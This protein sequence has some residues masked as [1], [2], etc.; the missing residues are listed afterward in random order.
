M[1]FL[2]K[3]KYIVSEIVGFCIVA[4]V[5]GGLIYW[6]IQKIERTADE[7]DKIRQVVSDMAERHNAST[8]WSE[9]FVDYNIKINGG[10]RPIYTT[11]VKTALIMNDSKP[12]IFCGLIVDVKNIDAEYYLLFSTFRDVDITFKLRCDNEQAER[13]MSTPEGFYVIVAVISNIESSDFEIDTSHN[14]APDVI[15]INSF[16]ANGVCLDFIFLGRD[17]NP[18][19]FV[20]RPQPDK[21]EEELLRNEKLEDSN[22]LY[23]H[24]LEEYLRRELLKDKYKHK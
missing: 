21:S 17:F 15:V 22:L 14:S 9:R 12:I 7:R 20:Q 5:V 8:Q 24:E 10:H 2:M 6:Y 19:E 23:D 1:S 16:I 18:Y 4:G 3:T 11:D 13:A